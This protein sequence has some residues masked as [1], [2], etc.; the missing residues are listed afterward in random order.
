[1]QRLLASLLAPVVALGLALGLAGCHAKA[2]VTPRDTALMFV[3]VVANDH[4]GLFLVDTGAPTTVLDAVYARQIGAKLGEATTL[5]GGGGAIAGRMAESVQMKA[6]GGPDTK[7]DPA[8][9]DLSHLALAF[10]YPIDGILGADY[11]GA[12]VMTLNYRTGNLHFDDPAKISP[13]PNAEPLH[14]ASAPYVR[15]V[16]Q[17]GGRKVEGVYQIDTGSNLAVA[18]WSPYA[19]KVFPDIPG[20]PAP[21]VG[22][23]GAARSRLA[24]LD[25][26]ELAGDRL[27]DVTVDVANDVHPDDAGPAY[28]GAIGGA[29]FKGRVLHLDYLRQKMWLDPLPAAYRAPV[30]P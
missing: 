5:R 11:F 12:Q 6:A 15:A 28:A 2:D 10:G 21:G 18:F 26:L 8:V 4:L 29:A 24:Q 7:L 20:S 13:P 27:T 30:K 25:A 1:M 14:V 17:M 22:V 9:T 23:G 3:N 16:A 19:R